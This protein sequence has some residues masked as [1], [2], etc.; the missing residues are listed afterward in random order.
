[1]ADI[2]P[3]TVSITYF[4]GSNARGALLSQVCFTD[5]NTSISISTSTFQTLHRSQ[6]PIPYNLMACHSGQIQI[7]LYDIEGSG[8]LSTDVNYLAA[9]VKERMATDTQGKT[10]IQ[11]TRI[12]DVQC[13]TQALYSRYL[14]NISIVVGRVGAAREATLMQLQCSNTAATAI[15]T[16][17]AIDHCTYIFALHESR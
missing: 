10:I 9:A 16:S 1:M 3:S 11:L 17:T 14:R 15:S 8:T 4:T 12:T 13:R 5:T 7:F 6:H 2:L